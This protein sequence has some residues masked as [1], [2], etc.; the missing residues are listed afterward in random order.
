MKE[1]RFAKVKYELR[2]P[3]VM[4]VEAE[5]FDGLIEYLDS[6]DHII[7]V[8]ELTENEAISYTQLMEKEAKSLAKCKLFN[9][10]EKYA[11]C[12]DIMLMCYEP[13]YNSFIV[14][15]FYNKEV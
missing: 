3:I 10:A 4:C 11:C 1:M 12:S 2:K 6:I 7:Y 14:L 15:D 5:M 13:N 9:E 8:D